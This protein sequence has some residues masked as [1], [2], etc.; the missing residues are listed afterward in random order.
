MSEGNTYLVDPEAEEEMIRLARQGRLLTQQLGLLPPNIDP[1][2]LPS[3]Q[4]EE[5]RPPFL[6]DIG[7]ATGEWGLAFAA[8]YRHTRVIGIDISERMIAYAA[9]QAENQELAGIAHFQIGNALTRFPFP[10]EYFDLIHLRIAN[11]FIPRDRWRDVF[12][13]CWRVLRPQ[14][15]LLSTEAESGITTCENPATA[16]ILRWFVQS[17]WISNLGFWDGV[18]S[19]IGIHAM[20]PV[21]FRNTG[22][23]HLEYFPHLVYASFGSP[24]YQAWLDG[25]PMMIQAVEPLVTGKLG[26]S[27]EDFQRICVESRIESLQDTFNVY[28]V[29]LSVTGRK[30]VGAG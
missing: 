11:G 27:K 30:S 9:Q 5:A 25:I 12:R 16:Q 19:A 10:N 6:L 2:Q 24:D 13:E 26:V 23:S 1:F 7:C 21:F 15:I 22:F 8:R 3:V 4:A 20:Q 29:C 18:G 14:G 28:I 17:L